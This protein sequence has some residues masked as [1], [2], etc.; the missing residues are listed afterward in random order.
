MRNAQEVNLQTQGNLIC[1]GNSDTDED[2]PAVVKQRSERWF[3][4]RKTPLVTGSTIH[5]AIGL[6]SLKKQREH[7]EV[8][9][10]KKEP[11]VV[12]A[13]LQAMFDH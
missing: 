11:P 5:K 4:I 9:P 13:D 2:V 10:G 6:D 3:Q 8:A 1:L 12:S 7:L